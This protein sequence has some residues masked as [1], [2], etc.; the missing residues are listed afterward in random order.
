MDARV[1]ALGKSPRLELALFAVCIIKLCI[2]VSISAI[3]LCITVAILEQKIWLLQ[4][5]EFANSTLTEWMWTIIAAYVILHRFGYGVCEH[6]QV[7]RWEYE[8]ASSVASFSSRSSLGSVGSIRSQSSRNSKISHRS[9]NS[10]ASQ[11]SGRS[12]DSIISQYSDQSIRSL[13]SQR[14]S[15]TII[16]H[17][18]NIP[19]PM[20]ERFMMFEDFQFETDMGKLEGTRYLDPVAQFYLR[21]GIPADAGQWA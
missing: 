20:L 12:I 17:R 3:K 1:L 19:S 15:T 6:P 11:H 21:K 14:T 13:I 8:Y 9:I 4:T 5:L 18:T 16:R 2:T 10:V 7:H